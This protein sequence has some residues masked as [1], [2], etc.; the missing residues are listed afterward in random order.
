MLRNGAGGHFGIGSDASS[1]FWVI[2]NVGETSTGAGP[3][4]GEY[5]ENRT[6]SGTPD[7][8]RQDATI[9]FN[10]GNGSP[11]QAIPTDDFSARWTSEIEFSGG[12]YEFLVTVDD[13]ARLWI[14][15]AKVLD[16]W[17]DGARRERRVSLPLVAGEHT[18]RLEY[19][20][21]TGAAT[22]KLSWAAVTSFDDWKGEYFSNRTLSGS[23]ALVRNDEDV[24]FDWRRGAPASGLPSDNFSARWTRRIT[25]EPGRYRLSTSADD[26]VRLIVAGNRV[27]DEWHDSSGSQV[28]SVDLD[29]SGR[30]KVVVE[31]Y[32]RS[33]DARVRFWYDR[34]ATPTSTVTPSI[35]PSPSSTASPTSSAT[36]SPTPSQTPT[37]SETPTASATPTSSETPTPSATA[38][39][40]PTH[41]PTC[42]PIECGPV[43]P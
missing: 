6:L 13:G 15:G 42:V 18:L 26:G 31:Y 9:D 29:L 37:P 19:Y 41:T 35:T 10:W 16:E 40:V 25:F 32:E 22:V 14:D 20:E 2:I 17:R 30:T 28:Y 5:F 12:T 43:I 7:L 23:P 1:A 3:W 4:L 27:I 11:A 38:S 8:T 24:N 34:L 36:T 21:R 33:G 39:E